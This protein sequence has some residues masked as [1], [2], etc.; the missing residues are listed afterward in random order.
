[1]LK[2]GEDHGTE[3]YDFGSYGEAV[4]VEDLVGEGSVRSMSRFD[5]VVVVYFA[6]DIIGDD[7]AKVWKFVDVFY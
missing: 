7:S 3:D 5:R 4:I 6:G 2:G 1:M